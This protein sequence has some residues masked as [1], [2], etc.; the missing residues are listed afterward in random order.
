VADPGGVRCRVGR[1]GLRGG[2]GGVAWCVSGRGCAPPSDT[3]RERFLYG[4]NRGHDSIAVFR[5]AADG[6]LAAVEIVP[7]RGRGPQNLAIT[8]DGGLLLCGNMAGDS[9]AVFRIHRDTGRLEPVGEPVAV[10]APSC[11][12]LVP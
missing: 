4:T 9:I 10:A 12:V 11:L 1:Y 2:P 6:T 3:P 5:V 7:S 8:P